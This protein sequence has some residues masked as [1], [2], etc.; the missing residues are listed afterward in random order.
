MVLM[1]GAA[2]IWNQDYSELPGTVQIVNLWQA[3]GKLW[4]YGKALSVVGRGTPRSGRRCAK[5]IS[6]RA[7]S[8]SYWRHCACM[9]RSAKYYA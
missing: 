1:V 6:R 2:W 3:K 5:T 4:E 7:A 8:S 9:R